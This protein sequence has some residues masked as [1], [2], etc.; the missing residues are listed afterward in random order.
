MKA[1]LIVVLFGFFLTV[2]L[3]AASRMD[4]SLRIAALVSATGFVQTLAAVG[5]VLLTGK[6]L[7][8]HDPPDAAS[9]PPNT[10]LTQTSVQTSTVAA[11]DDAPAKQP[12]G[13]AYQNLT[14]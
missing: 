11:T 12:Q 9:L 14:K 1:G 3:F 6:D 13:R 10:Q 2:Y 7:S 4:P 8:H 5:S